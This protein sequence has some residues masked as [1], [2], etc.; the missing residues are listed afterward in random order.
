[1]KNV[2]KEFKKQKF[3]LNKIIN[4]N[5]SI[6]N[7]FKIKK[8]KIIL[9]GINPHSGENGLISSDE[10]KYLLPIIK[11]LKQLKI[12]IKGPVSGDGIINISNLKNYNVFLFTYHDQALIPFKIISKY[13]GVNFTSNLKLIRVSPSHGTATNLVGL[14]KISSKG[15]VNCFKLVNEIYKNRK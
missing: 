15:I 14:K 10:I 12:N 4:I 13:E 7:D 5:K 1:M 9:A 2:Y 11:K 8:P 3:I 6:K